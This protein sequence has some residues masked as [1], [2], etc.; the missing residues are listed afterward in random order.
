MKLKANFLKNVLP[1]ENVAYMSIH[2]LGTSISWQH[3]ISFVYSKYTK[4][5]GTDTL[6]LLYVQIILS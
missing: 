2:L 1:T 6:K 5:T 4:Y 3:T